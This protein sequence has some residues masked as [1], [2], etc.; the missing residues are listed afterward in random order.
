MTDGSLP[1]IARCAHFWAIESPRGPLSLGVCKNC[2]EE[3][4]FRNSLPLSRWDTEAEKPNL[5]LPQTIP[6]QP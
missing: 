2:G 1:E 3:R 4:E 5:R 6:P